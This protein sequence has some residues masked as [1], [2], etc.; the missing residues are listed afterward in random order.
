MVNNEIKMKLALKLVETLSSSEY[1]EEEFFS[2]LKNMFSS[3]ANEEELED[4]LEEYKEHY[5][6]SDVKNRIA[7]IYLNNL[8]EDEMID[9]INFFNTPTGKTWVSK[10]PIILQQ[11]IKVSE[12]YG[13]S[14]AEQIIRKIEK[15]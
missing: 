2:L 8:T 11:I 14:I 12:E 4:F 6:V 3:I 15:N 9:M 10:H 7:E 1:N 5:S 13:A